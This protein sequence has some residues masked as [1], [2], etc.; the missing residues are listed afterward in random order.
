[1]VQN[2]Y[3][4]RP[5]PP[6][7]FHRRYITLFTLGLLDLLADLL[8]LPLVYIPT[9]EPPGVLAAISAPGA[10]AGF[11]SVAKDSR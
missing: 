4:G 10:L 1:M 11:G 6:F 9:V 3:C 2:P 5:L 8:H 7:Q